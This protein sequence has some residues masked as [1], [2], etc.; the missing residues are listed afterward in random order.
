MASARDARTCFLWDNCANNC[1]AEYWKIPQNSFLGAA[2]ECSQKASSLC[3]SLGAAIN[4]LK[5]ARHNTSM[6][7]CFHL[8][9]QQENTKKSHWTQICLPR[10]AHVTAP[11]EMIYRSV[12]CSGLFKKQRNRRCSVDSPEGLVNHV[13]PEMRLLIWWGL[14]AWSDIRA[15]AYLAAHK[16]AC[17]MINKSFWSTRAIAR[18]TEYS[19]LLNKRYHS[20]STG[21]RQGEIWT[22][23]QLKWLLCE[24]F[25]RGRVYRLMDPN[26]NRTGG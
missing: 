25:I 19:L 26:Q 9:L 10:N 20:G 14:Y 17:K 2:N 7:I 6:Q 24:N 5:V 13:L 4:K 3:L 8:K 18:S 1:A 16:A 15:M 11:S 23:R 12:L 21:D 22:Q